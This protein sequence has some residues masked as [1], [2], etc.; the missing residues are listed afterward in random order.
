MEIWFWKI[1][2]QGD[3]PWKPYNLCGAIHTLWSLLEVALGLIWV[4]RTLVWCLRP[5]HTTLWPRTDC[6][7]PYSHMVALG[8]SLHIFECKWSG[9]TKYTVRMP[10]RMGSG[11]KFFK[12]LDHHLKTSSWR[13]FSKWSGAEDAY[14]SWYDPYHPP[15][16]C[17]WW[18]FL[19]IEL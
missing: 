4:M 16:G 5:W 2:D 9:T 8:L 6:V 12:V 14:V 19:S 17:L 13:N 3:T 15:Y 7:R 10:F 11:M 1:L 18:I